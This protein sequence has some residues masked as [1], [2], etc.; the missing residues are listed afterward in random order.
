MDGDGGQ[1]A[2]FCDDWYTDALYVHD[3]ASG[4][5]EYRGP[6]YGCRDLAVG[7]VDTDLGLEIVVGRGTETG[8][9]LDGATR[10]VEWANFFGFGD[11]V[12][13]ANLDGLGANEIVTAYYWQGIALFDATQQSLF[14]SLPTSHDIGDMRVFDVEGDGPLEIVYGDGQWGEIHVHN[15]QT[16]AQKWIV[17][18]PEHGVSDIALGDVDQDGRRELLWGAEAPAPARTIFTSPTPPPT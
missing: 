4:A 1:E 14:A 18:N 17:D 3:L 2:V 13:I 11:Y 12:R 8:Y 16:L 10:A 15:G 9:V 5:E 6:G 7:N